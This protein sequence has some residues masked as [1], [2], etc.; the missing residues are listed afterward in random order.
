MKAKVEGGGHAPN[1]LKLLLEITLTTLD[2]SKSFN[3]I[4]MNKIYF[5][6]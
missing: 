3:E 1:F 2:F 4:E 6:N 5:Q